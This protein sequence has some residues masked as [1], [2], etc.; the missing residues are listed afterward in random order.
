V[1][2]GEQMTDTSVLY[3]AAIYFAV[4]TL[5]FYRGE[6]KPLED[7]QELGEFAQINDRVIKRVYEEAI[8]YLNYELSHEQIGTAIRA[9]LAA[10]VSLDRPELPA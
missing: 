4:A 6:L 5:Y 9:Y 8:E 3:R 7:G 1:K 10:P 2:K